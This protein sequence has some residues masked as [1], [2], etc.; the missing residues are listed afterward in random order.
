LQKALLFLQPDSSYVIEI[1]SKKQGAIIREKANVQIET[2]S[3]IQQEIIALRAE[4]KPEVIYD[5]S[6]YAKF[7]GNSFL[8]AYAA[9]APLMI[10]AFNPDE[11]RTAVAIYM[12]SS[13]SGFVIPLVST[14][15]SNVSKAHASMYI[16]G[17]IHGLYVGGALSA[18]ADMNV[19][20][21]TGALITAGASVIGEYIGFQSVNRFRLSMG[22][23]NTI[24]L[25]GDFTGATATGL[26][27]LFDNWSD[28]VFTHKYYLT[29]SIAGF[30]SGLF[31]GSVI[32]RKL[33]L[34]DGD[35]YIFGNCGIVGA[36][37]LPVI[38]S[39][40]DNGQGRISG[41][42]YISG[43]IAGLGL[44]SILGYK[45]IESKNFSESEGNIIALGGAAGAL[46]GAGLVFLSGTDNP[47]VYWTGI[48]AGDIIGAIATASF[49]KAGASDKHSHIHI[50]PES[51]FGIGI[52][53]KNKIPTKNQFIT[54]EF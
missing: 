31:L 42:M 53:L 27:S 16:T 49:I 18:I 20:E 24:F 10:M 30:G 51:I 21:G 52:S 12:L 14:K 7:L 33:D 26:L 39:Y 46:T 35:P 54:V 45:I 50:R 44:G 38:L 9:Q 22:R 41:K 29:T 36:A 25:I 23:G 43:G 11:A 34:T 37:S 1:Y 13:A 8:L 5:H 3:Q 4:E 28:P 47:K 17:G 6:G 15:N 32:T 2:I 19:F 48:I 40:F